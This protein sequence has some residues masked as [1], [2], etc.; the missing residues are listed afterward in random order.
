MVLSEYQD[1]PLR[2]AII[3]AG[4]AG[5]GAAIAFSRLP[6]VSWTLY[7]KGDRVKEIGAGISI[8]RNTWQILEDFGA[9][10][11]IHPKDIYRP[12]DRNNRHH[13]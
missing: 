13:R 7:E 5:L 4:P 8:Q 2:V 10:K 6:F 1:R 9:A 3:G 12:R 11:N